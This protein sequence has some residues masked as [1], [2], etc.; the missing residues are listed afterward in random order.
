M[1]EKKR[2]KNISVF[3]P[4]IQCLFTIFFSCLREHGSGGGLVP[5][6]IGGLCGLVIGLRVLGYFWVLVLVSVFSQVGPGLISFIISFCLGL[7]VLSTL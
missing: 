5:I 6:F 1:K 2:K 7:R 4:V 3:Y